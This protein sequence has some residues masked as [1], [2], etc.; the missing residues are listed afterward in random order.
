MDRTAHFSNPL[1]DADSEHTVYIV[2]EQ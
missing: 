2:Y 1:T